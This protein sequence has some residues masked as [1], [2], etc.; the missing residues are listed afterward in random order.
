MSRSVLV[1]DK[2]CMQCMVRE[3]VATDSKTIKLLVCMNV[4]MYDKSSGE[5]KRG[6]DTDII[7]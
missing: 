5:Q 4:V 7:L 2:N 3:A 1:L 6:K